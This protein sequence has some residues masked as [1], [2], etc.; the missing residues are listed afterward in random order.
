MLDSLSVIVDGKFEVVDFLGTAVSVDRFG[1]RRVGRTRNV[2]E[3]G[4]ALGVAVVHFFTVRTGPQSVRAVSSFE[5]L[6]VAE[7]VAMF[8][9]GR[10]DGGAQPVKRQRRLQLHRYYKEVESETKNG[11]MKSN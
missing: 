2:H 1:R 10:V 4:A 3:A 11:F 7:F 6:D 8:G 5:S 9:I